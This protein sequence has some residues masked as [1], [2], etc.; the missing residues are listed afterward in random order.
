M[1][2]LRGTQEER[3]PS[4]LELFPSLLEEAPLP[5]IGATRPKHS[6]AHHRAS[7]RQIEPKTLTAISKGTRKL[8]RVIGRAH[9][10]SEAERTS[11][12]NRMFALVHSKQEDG[13]QDEGLASAIQTNPSFE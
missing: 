4:Y 8:L 2:H 5:T 7:Q 6:R 12:D 1:S 13:C 3:L 10:A 11:H 9:S